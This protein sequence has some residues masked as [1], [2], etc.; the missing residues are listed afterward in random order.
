MRIM[1]IATPLARSPIWSQMSHTECPT[2]SAVFLYDHGPVVTGPHRSLQHEL[3][4][5]REIDIH[6]LAVLQARLVTPLPDGR[7]GRLVEPEFLT[8]RLQ[9]LD[10]PH[11]AVLADDRLQ[12]DL[13]LD[14][15]LARDLR[16]LGVDLGRGDQ[17]GVRDAADTGVERLV[18]DH[19][20]ITAP[21]D[22]PDPATADA[23][24]H[25]ADAPARAP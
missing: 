16:I 2:I 14:L 15:G 24:H 17:L 5:H 3:H 25:P 23:A 12:D 7:H 4:E 18:A 9:D 8:G 10:L 21:R 19:P 1:K 6:G 13:A 11:R 22:P 20:P